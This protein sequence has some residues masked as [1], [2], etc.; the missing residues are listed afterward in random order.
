MYKNKQINL[1]KPTEFTNFSFG[2]N[3]NLLGDKYL[4]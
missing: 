4:Q 2:F 1:K 3:V